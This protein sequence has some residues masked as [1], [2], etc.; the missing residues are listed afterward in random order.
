MRWS[1]SLQTQ[2]SELIHNFYGSERGLTEQFR[3]RNI[4]NDI[5]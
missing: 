4:N 2:R 5:Y 1:K 3:S